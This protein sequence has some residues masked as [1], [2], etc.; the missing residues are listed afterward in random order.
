MHSLLI[1]ADEPYFK[2]YAS[3]GVGSHDMID[4]HIK[5]WMQNTWTG[6]C[7]G[8]WPGPHSIFLFGFLIWL[9]INFLKIYCFKTILHVAEYNS[10]NT[11][12]SLPSGISYS[13]QK[14]VCVCVG[15]VLNKI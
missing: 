7:M 8:C 3:L 15:G 10:R 13:L 5:T 2:V 1:K 11:D 14:G 4:T 6:V 9:S 12:S